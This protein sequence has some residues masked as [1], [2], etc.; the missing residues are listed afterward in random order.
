MHAKHAARHI[1][2]NC[3]D[4][5]PQAGDAVGPAMQSD[6]QQIDFVLTNE[7]DNSIDRLSI[8]QMSLKLDFIALGRGTRCGLQSVVE[9]VAILI[10]GYQKGRVRAGGERRVHREVCHYRNRMKP[11]PKA[12][13]EP[14]RGDQR[15]AGLWRFV[16]GYGNVLVHFSS[17]PAGST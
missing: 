17:R 12:I 10:E 8:H 7:A 3:I 16:I 1:L 9:L 5:T 11:S 14:D 4:C 2:S 6:H 15:S 13:C